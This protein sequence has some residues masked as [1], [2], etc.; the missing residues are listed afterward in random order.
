M[1]KSNSKGGLFVGILIGIV[2]MLVVGGC[3][4]ATK[5]I[6][7]SSK[8]DSNN[9]NKKTVSNNI[10]TKDEAVAILKEK[11]NVSRKVFDLGM[12]SYC[13]E[14]AT[15]DNS[16][17]NI[18]D[19]LYM[20]SATYSSFEELS[21]YLKNYMTEELLNSTKN[22]NDSVSKSYYEENGNLYCNTRNKGSDVTYSIF[23]D[24]ESK[25]TI[26]E[27]NEKEIKATIQAVYFDNSETSKNTRI[28]DVSMIKNSDKWLINSY[29]DKT[30]Y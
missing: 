1:E 18:N 24:D 5:T 2:I 17:K 11:Y 26:N 23:I 22:Y 3:L 21:N 28:I 10:L 29:E 4:F 13:G 12:I 15:G 16:S 6:S 20:K 19:T 27:I 25:Y 8:T 30:V 7:F 14:Y 9:V